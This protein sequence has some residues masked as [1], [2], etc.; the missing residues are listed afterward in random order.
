MKKYPVLVFLILLH[1]ISFSQDETIKLA[2]KDN[3]FYIGIDNP[4]KI[5]NSRGVRDFYTACINGTIRKTPISGNFIVRVKKIGIV[6]IQLSKNGRIFKKVEIKSKRIPNPYATIGN[7][8]KEN[9]N[10]AIS[11][12]TLLASIG[13][14]ARLDFEFEVKFN[15]TSF[16]I[17]I[18][19]KEGIVTKSTNSARFSTSQKSL[20]VDLRRGAQILF[21]NIR[22]RCPDGTIRKLKSITIK[23]L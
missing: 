6:K 13:L 5:T 18:D 21:D 16:D 1:Y 4:V 14:K 3:V 8:A 17:T 23:L 10:K 19:T 22:A 11:K 2:S 9:L 12:K 20:I 15:I 7:I